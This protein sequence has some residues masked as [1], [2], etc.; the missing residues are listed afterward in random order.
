MVRLTVTVNQDGVALPPELLRL[1]RGECKIAVPFYQ[2][3]ITIF[4]IDRPQMVADNNRRAL[5]GAYATAAGYW[6]IRATP[7]LVPGGI[8]GSF[9]PLLSLV[10]L[11]PGG[12]LLLLVIVR[13][14]QA[15]R[16]Y[17]HWSMRRIRTTRRHPNI[18][19]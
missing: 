1:T 11:V 14:V 16:F 15:F 13:L 7:F 4:N 10:L 19:E 18:Y 8:V 2:K 17:P 9:F 6:L 3:W 12:C 5:N